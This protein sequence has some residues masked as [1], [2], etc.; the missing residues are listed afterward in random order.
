MFLVYFQYVVAADASGTST[1]DVAIDA[2]SVKV[3]IFFIPASSS[4]FI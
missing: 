1:T 3:I 4:P 2:E